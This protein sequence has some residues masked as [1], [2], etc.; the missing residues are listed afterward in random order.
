MSMLRRSRYLAL[1]SSGSVVACALAANPSWA[2]CSPTSAGNDIVACDAGTLPDPTLAAVDLQAGDDTVTV[3]S[4]TYSGGITGGAGTKTISFLGGSVASYTNTVGTSLITI[5]GTATVTGDVTTGG[6]A[7]SFTINAGSVAGTVRQGLGIDTFTM[8]GGQI[9]A[10]LQSDGRDV[11]TMTGGTIIG[12]FEDG[13]VATMTGG[14]IGRVDMKLDNNI[15]DMSGGTIIGNLVA[16]FGNDTITITNGTIGGNIS[17][18][19][20]TDIVTITGGAVGGNILMSAGNDSFTW[21]GGGTIGGFVEMGPGDD[22]VILR[23]LNLPATQRIT[24]NDGFDT[25]TLGGN[26]SSSLNASLVTGFETLTKTDPGTWTLSGSITDVQVTTVQQGTLRLTGSN[27]G[28]AGQMI[29]DPAGTLEGRAQSMVP[30]VTNNGLVR[31]AQPDLGVYAGTI[32]GA[33]ALEKTEAGTLVLTSANTYAGGTTITQGT[34]Q[35][36]NGGTSGSIVGNVVDNGTLA[37]NRSDVVTFAGTISGTGSL[38]QAGS[39]TTVLTAVNSVSGAVQVTSGTLAIGNAA[40]PLAALSG[41]GLVTVAAGATFGGY[42]SVAGSV[43]NAGTLAVADAIP[44]FA[45]GPKGSFTIGGT[46]T[47]AGLAQVGGTGIGNRLVVRDYVGQGGQVA[48]NTF[49][50]SD[51]SPSDRLVIDGG[52]AS[53]TSALRI[54]NVGGPGAQTFASGILVVEATNGGVTNASAFSLA[55]PVAAGA[56]EYLLF[57]GGTEAGTS[58]N[59]Y[60]RNTIEPSDPVAPTTPAPG[61]PALPAAPPPGTAA[62][63]LYRPE[64]PVYAAV[65]ALARQLGLTTLGTFHQ[66]QGEQGLL[67]GQGAVTAGWGRV[68]GQHTEQQLKGTV[69]PEFKGRIWG[70]QTGLDLYGIDRADGHRDRFGLFFGYGRADGDIRGFAIGQRRSPVG[71]LDLDSYSLGAYWTHIGPSGWYVDTVLMTSWLNGDGR[72]DRGVTGKVDGNA[73][74]ASIEGGYP[75]ALG[76]GWT[77]EPQAQLIWQ[78]LSLDDTRD[79]FS[80]IAF[81]DSDALTGRLGARLQGRFLLG[82][83]ELQPYLNLNLWHGFNRTD[84]VVF[85]ASDVIATKSGGTSLEIG[86]GLVAKLSTAVSVYATGGYTT[87][88]SGRDRRTLQGNLGVRVVW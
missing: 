11:F 20:G 77:L 67:A 56:Y 38:V 1:L 8:T 15:F 63:P 30:A 79:R 43:T 83:T 36:G 69:D 50:G 53:G 18:S 4:G 12:A 28:Y 2:G 22:T 58:Q 74:T 42:G 29:V 9:Q 13:D 49:L 7:D 34:L 24:G 59:W 39:G 81:G 51:G 84:K 25:M 44:A 3:N 68:F 48:L 88:L 76:G 32:S 54:S 80:T 52:A 86:G 66:R 16:G 82:A 57:H 5:D 31:F 37:F 41:G 23:D 55:G 6:A 60:L 70:L 21:S 65:P 87:E 26:G 62:I 17:V 72:S 73:V 10:L 75:I 27:A 71:K 78:H 61:T 85:D 64:V 40:T 33:G 14:T 19:G 46:L 35:L 47:N 45:G